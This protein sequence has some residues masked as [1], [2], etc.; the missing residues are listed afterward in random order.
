MRREEPA[1][2]LTCR[3]PLTVK[4]LLI[5]CRIHIDTRQNLKLPDNLFEALSPTHDNTNKIIT[6]L[7]LTD[8]IKNFTTKNLF[9][10]IPS[11]FALCTFFLCLRSLSFLENSLGHSGHT[12]C[13]FLPHSKS[14]CL[15]R[16]PLKRNIEYLNN[17]LHEGNGKYINLVIITE[18]LN[19]DEL[20][21]K[22]FSFNL[23]ITG[24][25][26][27]FDFKQGKRYITISI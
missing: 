12:N 24:L 14:R 2:C 7:K 8:I 27:C 20:K 15:R 26:M 23:N 17:L 13:G 22:K 9:Q 10:K 3:E 21:H 16:P 19:K 6:F 4:Q 25:T 18:Y 5:H 11:S 1:M